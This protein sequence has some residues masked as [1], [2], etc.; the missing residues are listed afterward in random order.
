MHEESFYKCALV[1]LLSVTEIYVLKER[2][3]KI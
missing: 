2:I 1:L 3:E